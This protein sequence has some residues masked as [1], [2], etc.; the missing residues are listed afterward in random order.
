[1]KDFDTWNKK[2]R[3][4]EGRDK[5]PHFHQREVWWCS[6]GVNIGQEQDG[7]GNLYE[8]PVLILFKFSKF[9]ALIV[10]MSSKVKSGIYYFKY[11]QHDSWFVFILSQVRFVSSKRLNKLL[12]K[13]SGKDFLEIIQAITAM[14]D[15][16]DQ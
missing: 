10:P 5:A 12:Y 2:K 16:L 7:K 9:A 3:E 4:I 14:F 8:R 15:A 11:K 1:M 13:V 6:L